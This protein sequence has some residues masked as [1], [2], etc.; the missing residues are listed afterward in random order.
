MRHIR[1]IL[2]CLFSATVLSVLIIMSIVLYSIIESVLFDF[3]LIIL[4]EHNLIAIIEFC[5]MIYAII[6]WFHW[7]YKEAIEFNKEKEREIKPKIKNNRKG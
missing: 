1:I 5:I 7:V 6:Y 4:Y 2:F 3:R